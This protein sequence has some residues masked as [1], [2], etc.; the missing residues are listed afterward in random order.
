MA[1]ESEFD[2][3]T[4]F[5][6]FEAELAD[7]EKYYAND[8]KQKLIAVSNIDGTIVGCVAF[9][10]LAPGVSEMKRLYVVPGYR[11]E[12]LGRML[13]EAIIEKA[14]S[15]GYQTMVLDTMMEMKAAQG[16]YRALG[17]ENIPP[18]NFQQPLKVICFG[19]TLN[20][21]NKNL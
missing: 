21:K 2:D 13:A 14:T 16:L 12:K 7:I 18:Y 10:K 17:F 4:C 3:K 8:D 11:G 15:L 6:S 1:Y 19:K 5:T 9:R 20:E